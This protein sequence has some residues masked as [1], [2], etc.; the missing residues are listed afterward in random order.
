[1]ISARLHYQTARLISRYRL[2]RAGLAEKQNL[3]IVIHLCGLG[4]GQQFAKRALKLKGLGRC[5][6]H[7]PVAYIKK[8]QR[9]ERAFQALARRESLVA[10]F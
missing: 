2:S 8:I 3:A 6:D 4:R 7:D 9:L 10:G 1:M 5:G